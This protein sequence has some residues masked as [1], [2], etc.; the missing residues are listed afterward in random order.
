MNSPAT[1]PAVPAGANERARTRALRC[2][3]KP[4]KLFSDK[5]S[6]D[7]GEQ[8]RTP[9]CCQGRVHDRG[10]RTNTLAQGAGGFYRIVAPVGLAITPALLSLSAFSRRRLSFGLDPYRCCNTCGRLESRRH[11]G[12][13]GWYAMDPGWVPRTDFQDWRLLLGA[14]AGCWGRRPQR[15]GVREPPKK[16]NRA[17]ARTAIASLIRRTSVSGP[18]LKNVSDAV[19]F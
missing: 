15:S 9:M 13:A 6:A 17:E 8:K 18:N 19:G 16:E 7:V 12:R 5:S 4:L 1:V 2:G 3:F 11:N 10:N 14:D